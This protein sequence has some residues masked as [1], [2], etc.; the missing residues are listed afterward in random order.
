[1]RFQG[2]ML[3]LIVISIF[4]RLTRSCTAAW[5]GKLLAG[6]DLTVRPFPCVPND[7]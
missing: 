5:P 7:Q 1:M 6:L 4:D 2:F 3:V